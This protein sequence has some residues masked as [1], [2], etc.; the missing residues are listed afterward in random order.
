MSGAERVENRHRVNSGIDKNAGLIGDLQVGKVVICKHLL[1]YPCSETSQNPA[2]LVDYH[3]RLL[4]LLEVGTKQ[5]LGIET[6]IVTFRANLVVS[7]LACI[8]K[9]ST[10]T[11]STIAKTNFCVLNRCKT[12]ATSAYHEL[13]ML[14]SLS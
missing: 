14:L 6:G 8:K 12:R 9:H 10:Q 13:D 7:I 2:L 5:L 1:S 4:N 3:Y 11:W